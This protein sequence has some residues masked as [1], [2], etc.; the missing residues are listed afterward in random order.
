LNSAA[1][2]AAERAMASGGYS[3]AGQAAALAHQAIHYLIEG[4]ERD[5]YGAPEIK[6]R[7]SIAVRR[8]EAWAKDQSPAFRPAD[9]P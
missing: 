8:A 6:R 7:F 5:Q 4:I 3:K 9:E 2:D 1:V